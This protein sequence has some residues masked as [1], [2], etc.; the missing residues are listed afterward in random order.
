MNRFVNICRPV[1]FHCLSCGEVIWNV[2]FCVYVTEQ[3]ACQQLQFFQ[4]GPQEHINLNFL[5]FAHMSA[6]CPFYFLINISVC[7][8]RCLALSHSQSWCLFLPLLFC[9]RSIYTPSF[10]SPVQLLSFNILISVQPLPVP[11]PASASVVACEW[12]KVNSSEVLFALI[13]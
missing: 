4:L 5:L 13:M 9:S 7:Q 12:W 2:Y 6:S 11:F 1:Q 3:V 10:S 8:L